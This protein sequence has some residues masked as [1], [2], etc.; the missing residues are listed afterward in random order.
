M[1]RTSSPFCR[2]YTVTELLI[3]MGLS[4]LILVGMGLVLQ[5][6][7]HAYREQGAAVEAARMLDATVKQIQRDLQLAGVGPSSGTPAI[8]PGHE[9]GTPLITIHSPFVTMLAADASDGSELFRIPHKAIRHFRQGDQVLVQGYGKSLSFQVK[10]VQAGTRP[11]LKPHRESLRS[12][13]GA[14]LRLAFPRGSEVI[15]LR[16]PEVQYWLDG[17]KSGGRRL[18]RRRGT[19]ERVLATGVQ[20]IH[21]EYL[22]APP[23]EQD[24]VGPQWTAS[25]A[26]GAQVL[27]ARVRLAVGRASVRFTVTPRNLLSG[28]SL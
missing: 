20:D 9:D 15:R 17:D 13:A 4:A 7:K 14:S 25:P 11:G 22:V 16:D 10:A 21:A 27:A 24:A 5:V 1:E 18:L 19:R 8:V 3:A 2:G 12:A 23:A 26:E 28:P 6:Q